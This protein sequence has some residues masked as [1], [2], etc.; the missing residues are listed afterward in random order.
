MIGEYIKEKEPIKMEVTDEFAK[1]FVNWVESHGGFTR[2]A[3]K[4]KML[5]S[6]DGRWRVAKF[7]EYQQEELR[8]VFDSIPSKD[9]S[10][11]ILFVDLSTPYDTFSK[12][13]DLCLKK[14]M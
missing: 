10:L 14:N 6:V 3:Q 4:H 12:I 2:V 8:D 1:D 5:V 7:S 9:M 13:Y 11:E